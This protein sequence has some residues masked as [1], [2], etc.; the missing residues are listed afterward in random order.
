MHKFVVAVVV[1]VA[2][3]SVALAD[4]FTGFITKV[5]DG[6]VTYYPFNFK[7]KEKGDTKTL[8]ATADVKV[9]EGKFNKEDFKIE[10]GDKIEKG[11]K[12][13]MFSKIDTEKGKGLFAL[14][15]TDKDNKMVT[16]I[17]VMQFKKK[18]Q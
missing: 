5:D 6:K 4:E 10:A 13:E 3:L 12:N 16:E 18:N 15:I 17:R 2:S 7:E 11:L 8:P 9:V 14:I 1:T